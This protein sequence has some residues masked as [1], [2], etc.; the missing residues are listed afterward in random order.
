MLFIDLVPA[1]YLAISLIKERFLL[2]A[3]ERLRR[4][5]LISWEDSR[6]EDYK[7]EAK[8]EAYIKVGNKLFIKTL[9][10]LANIVI[11]LFLLFFIVWLAIIL[12]LRFL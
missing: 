11:L 4:P 12:T 9:W 2:K 1:N 5:L 3:V 10:V 6:K 8:E 7:E